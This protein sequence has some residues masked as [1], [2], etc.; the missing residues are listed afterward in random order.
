MRS[1]N[2]IIVEVGSALLLITILG[3]FKMPVYEKGVEI[4]VSAFVAAFSM[5]IGYK[6]GRSMPEQSGDPKPGQT[7]KT[8]TETIPPPAE[9]P[10]QEPQI[11]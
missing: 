10:A 5:I 6:F 11:K 8:V 9:T 4:V 3:F 1:E 2:W 7:A